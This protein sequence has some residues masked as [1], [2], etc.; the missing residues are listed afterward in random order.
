[1]IRL[2]PNIISD[3]Q[4]HWRN[5]LEIN[6]WTRQNGLLT[7]DEH[8]KWLERIKNDP[9]I[10]MFGIQAEICLHDS[11]P[12]VHEIG[13]CGFTSLSLI[14]GTAEFSLLIAPEF[15]KQGFGKK[16]LQALLRYGFK[17]MRLNCIWGETFENNPA[18][19]MFKKIGMIEEGRHL[20][21]YWKNGTFVDSVTY[22]IRH[23]EAAS[24]CPW[25]WEQD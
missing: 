10:K 7:F 5:H 1:M 6:R 21:R 13:T 24:S 9:T 14:H 12:D 20:E 8:K 25:Y 4:F 18:R 16:A 19:E 2:H 3:H 23:R 22:S 15:Q 11:Y 17:N